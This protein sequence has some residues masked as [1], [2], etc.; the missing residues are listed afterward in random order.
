MALATLFNSIHRRSWRFPALLLL[1][2]SNMP[3]NEMLHF[4]NGFTLEAVSHSQQGEILQVQ[5]GSGS[6]EFPAQDIERIDAFAPTA[7]RA[8]SAVDQQKEAS[9]ETL[10]SNAALAQGI[11]AAFVRSVARVESGLHQDRI[12]RKGAIGLMQ[13]M[14]G[15]AKDLGVDAFRPDEN[16]R[17]GVQYLRSLLLRYQ[18]NSALALAAYNAGP[19]AVERFRGVPPYLETRRYVL[20][21]LSEYNRQIRLQAATAK[22]SSAVNKPSAIN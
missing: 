20:L 11:D 3:A 4:K 19:G 1:L 8:A 12:S 5:V 15:T 7:I 10:L 18:G 16:A 22:S 6:L 17:G 9:P 13:L 21:V 14:P 2:A